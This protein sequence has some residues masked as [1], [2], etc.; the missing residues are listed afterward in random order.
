MKSSQLNRVLRLARRTGDKIIVL[1]QDTDASFVVMDLDNYEEFLDESSFGPSA[2][3]TEWRDNSAD[4]MSEP[5][6]W[7]DDEDDFAPAGAV[8]K[9][10]WGG[11]SKEEL[12]GIKKSEQDDEVALQEILSEP[13]TP[14]LA[15]P[16][17]VTVPNANGQG[18][19]EISLSDVPHDEQDTFLLE[20]VE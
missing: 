15:E 20:P 16:E 12:L 4:P 11:L 5:D 8:L 1:D 14:P 9:N 6:S 13:I 2:D 10:R 18:A 3:N 17:I 19:E 7:E